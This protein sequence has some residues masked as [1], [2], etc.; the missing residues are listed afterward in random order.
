METPTAPASSAPASYQTVPA[1]GSTQENSPLLGNSTVAGATQTVTVQV[2]AIPAAAPGTRQANMSLLFGALSMS[3]CPF[4][5]SI[6]AIVF[7]VIALSLVKPGSSSISTRA[8]AGLLLGLL[9]FIATIVIVVVAL[10][11]I[12]AI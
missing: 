10:V 7:G 4:I 8:W 5:G 9:T 1:Q 12:R 11:M 3:C 2:Y 6:I